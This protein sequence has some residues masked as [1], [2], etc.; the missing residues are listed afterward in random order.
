M[1][2]LTVS[3]NNSSKISLPKVELTPTNAQSNRPSMSPTNGPT[4]AK[5]K[6]CTLM[7]MKLLHI[8]LLILMAKVSTK[9]N[10]P[11]RLSEWLKCLWDMPESILRTSRGWE[12]LSFK[13]VAM[14]CSALWDDMDFIMTVLCLLLKRVGH[15]LW[16][17]GCLILVL[18]NLVQADLI[19]VST[20]CHVYVFVS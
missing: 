6:T 20:C 3:T 9:S 10:G 7:V 8:P 11:M 5:S 13:L 15:T 2:L 16:N 18:W 17:I 14:L 12:L 4:I 19:Q 1:M